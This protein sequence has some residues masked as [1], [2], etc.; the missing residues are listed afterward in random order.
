MARITKTEADKVSAKLVEKIDKEIA[1][2]TEELKEYITEIYKATIPPDVMKLWKKEKLWIEDANYVYISGPGISE[3]YDPYH[4]TESWPAKGSSTPR[5]EL[6]K[7]QAAHTTKLTDK[8][9]DLKKKKSSTE[10][11]IYNLLLSLGTWKRAAEQLPEIKAY[12]PVQGNRGVM[13]I[14]SKTREKIQCLITPQDTT[15]LE[16]M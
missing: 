2:A 4:L 7:D 12:M 13:I 3:R 14:P 11:E 16:T 8:V 10:T 1:K 6:D 9:A 5:L 15:C